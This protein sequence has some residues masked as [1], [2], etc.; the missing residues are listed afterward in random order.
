[1]T[2]LLSLSKIKTETEERKIE[3]S[4]FRIKDM[5]HKRSLSDSKRIEYEQCLAWAKKHHKVGKH[6]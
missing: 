4:S 5:K 1:M 2:P 6:Y 3:T